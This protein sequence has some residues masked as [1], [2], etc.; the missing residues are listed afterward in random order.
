MR[1]K[2][3]IN[4]FRC[5]LLFYFCLF[6]TG[7]S[8]V[9]ASE[10]PA[11]AR[12]TVLEVME[13]L[14]QSHISH[15]QAETL[16]N[17]AIQ[18][19]I[20]T[21]E[22]PYTAYLTEE[23]L[24]QLT[25]DLNGSFGGVGLYL[26]GRPD[27]PR[28]QEVFTNSPAEK[29][30]MK[31][32]DIIKKVD[33]TDIKGWPLASAVERIK[34]AVGTDVVLVIDREGAEIIV[35]LK[36]EH[37]SVPTTESKIV[38]EK[39]GYIAVK[40]FGANTPKQFRTDLDR[41]LSKNIT[42]LLIDLRDNPGGY[43]EAALEMAEIFVEPDTPIL[44]TRNY[45]GTV[46]KH[47]S[48]KGVKTVKIPAV[49][50]I[51][52]LSASSSEILAGALQDNGAVTLVGEKSYGKG[53]AQSIVKLSTGGALKITTTE[54]TTPKGRQVNNK[55]LAPD[56]EVLTRELQLPFALRILEPRTRQVVFTPGGKEILV[57]GEKIQARNGVLAKEDG[58]YLPFRFT[59]EALGWVLSWDEN[60]ASITAR[61]GNTKAVFPLNGI[62]LIN[63]REMKPGSSI[64][65]EEGVSYIP[66]V[67]LE[68]LGIK[69]SRT[70]SRI[71]VEG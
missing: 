2:F 47:L 33:G 1:R 68:E 20:D 32:G 29:A 51:N 42:G 45:D 39:T 3:V 16:V 27:Y 49:V 63:G 19:M 34:G 40:S 48:E 37:L 11:K 67:L 62:S 5:F 28:V 24:K 15:P 30:G 58:I 21:L 9:Y 12:K 31:A 54:Y 8:L 52:A 57:G 46:V 22:D 18:G 36:R 41:L 38:G 26:E 43:L 50:L 64:Y 4:L 55:G 44:I 17:G 71:V 61:N 59:L 66:L 14:R 56:F 70:D 6:L 53:V 69:V 23:E 35:G 25:D 10:D 60:T 7:N 13:Y 65:I